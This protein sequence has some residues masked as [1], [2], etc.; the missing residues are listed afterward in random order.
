MRA[1]AQSDTRMQTVPALD[2]QVEKM[3]E[4]S[5]LIKRFDKIRDYM[6]D[7]YVYGFKSRAD[8][9]RK[10]LRTYDNERRRAQSYLGDYLTWD[11]H[12]GSKTSFISIDCA[13]IPVNPLYAAWKSK[14]F[15]ANDIMLHF[16]L[17]DLLKTAKTL[18]E[19]TQE[20]C[21]KSEV[22][23]DAQTVR[24]KCNEYALA[25][26]L[27]RKKQGKAY[28]Y[29]IMKDP[30]ALSSELIDAVAFFQ[31][32][33]PFGEVG[34]FILDREDSGNDLFSF[35]HHYIAH[36]LEDGVLLEILTALREGRLVTFENQSSRTQHASLF[37]ALPLK[38]F[39]SAQTGRRY[40]CMYS[41]VTGRFRNY[42][43]DHIKAV[44][45]G[46]VVAE[47]ASLRK[48]LEKNLGKAWGVSFGG[49]SRSET[50]SIKLRIDEKSEQYLIDRI[51][52]EGQ[53]GT[54]TKIADNV[55]L[56]TKEVFDTNDM[57]P[58]IKT[59]TGRIIAL[60]GTNQQVVDRFYNDMKELASMY[61]IERTKVRRP[62]VQAATPPE[63]TKRQE[64]RSDSVSPTNRAGL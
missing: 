12:D 50:V 19:L 64:G 56:F 9:T 10:S 37:E 7:F 41:L 13:R 25:G 4:F 55:F 5:E 32:A 34:S 20:I 21:E 49:R 23:F 61:G 58:W 47:A 8:F 14:S 1:S 24:N 43:L 57:T 39:I 52:R 22:I 51:Q 35:K 45:L 53:G 18:E 26:M 31:G 63:E 33:A 15:T 44:K 38:I 3:A 28:T 30:V 46:D 48:K 62:R 42:R 54:L 60:T 27:E 59:F 17:L 2:I 36:T 6:R 16:Y 11:Y 29:Q 40:A